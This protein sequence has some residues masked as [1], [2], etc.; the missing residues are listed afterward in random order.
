MED[1]GQKWTP[2]TWH[3]EQWIWI[4][5]WYLEIMHPFE[6]WY[7]LRNLVEHHFPFKP[8]YV[9]NYIHILSYT[10]KCMGSGFQS[11]GK[12]NTFLSLMTVRRY[13]FD[14][15]VMTYRS[16]FGYSAILRSFVAW[17]VFVKV[18]FLCVNIKCDDGFLP[19]NM[20]EVFEKNKHGFADNA[21]TWGEF[22][23]VLHPKYFWE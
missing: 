6:G 1:L 4:I 22:K 21:T 20:P 15:C 12:P 17:V 13:D 2:R 16:Q 11:T 7:Q 3:F 18:I 23:P 5:G 8:G 9:T 10:P 19:Y 14:D